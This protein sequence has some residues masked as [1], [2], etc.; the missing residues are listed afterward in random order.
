MYLLTQMLEYQ[1][2]A[3]CMSS[4][5]GPQKDILGITQQLTSLT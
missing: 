2:K 3:A 5:M 4:F 1:Q